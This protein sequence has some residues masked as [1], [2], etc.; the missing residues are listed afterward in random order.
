MIKTK[1][2]YLKKVAFALLACSLL[3]V[4]AAHADDAERMTVTPYEAQALSPE[5]RKIAVAKRTIA[6]IQEE[7]GFYYQNGASAARHRI[8]DVRA[9]KAVIAHEQQGPSHMPTATESVE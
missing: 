5:Q 4:Q 2:G 6:S 9:E 8:D 3:G 7:Q 1:L